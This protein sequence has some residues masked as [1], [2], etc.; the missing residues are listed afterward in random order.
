[1][2]KHLLDIDK[3]SGYEYQMEDLD[4]YVA[5]PAYFF[6]R[7]AEVAKA[8]KY[9]QIEFKE[10]PTTLCTLYGNMDTLASRV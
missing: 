6:E 3:Q 9:S 10:M 4:G 8:I 1:M 5:D 7:A 2:T